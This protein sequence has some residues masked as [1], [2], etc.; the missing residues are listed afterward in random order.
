[1][2]ESKS[3]S[4]YTDA[5]LNILGFFTTKSAHLIPIDDPTFVE[6][7]ET[8]KEALFR[9]FGNALLVLNKPAL[10]RSLVHMS[11]MAI[12]MLLESDQ[13]KTDNESTVMVLLASWLEVNSTSMDV[14]DELCGLVRLVQLDRPYLSRVLPALAGYNARQR[15][16]G[17][18]IVWTIREGEL[19]QALVD[20]SGSCV[21]LLHRVPSHPSTAA[22]R[23]KDWFDAWEKPSKWGER[24]DLAIGG[25]GRAAHR[26]S[27]SIEWTL[28]YF[29][30]RRTIVYNLKNPIRRFPEDVTGVVVGTMG[31][32]GMNDAIERLRQKF[33]DAAWDHLDARWK[34]PDA[35]DIRDLLDGK[36]Q[37][38]MRGSFVGRAIVT[39][40]PKQL[41]MAEPWDA[42]PKSLG[43]YGNE[44][45]AFP[46]RRGSGLAAQLN[47]Y[48]LRASHNGDL[49][50]LVRKHNM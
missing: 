29:T 12:K 36:I 15:A 46:C 1:M 38:L 6:V 41:G 10:H 26:T 43:P 22:V 49:A 34:S 39:Q 50:R 23:V 25:I 27:S 40:H 5:I 17:L 35:K 32:T 31:S 11:S 20:A 37:G 2:L 47:A 14:R 19:R 7:L 45:F 28:P 48:L 8:A 42:A 9:E 33:G 24:V 44:V 18:V 13:L 30:V 16:T 21:Q 4:S 3:S